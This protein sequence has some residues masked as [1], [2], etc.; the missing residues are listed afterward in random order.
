MFA[1]LFLGLLFFLY[2]EID[3]NFSYWIRSYR[4]SLID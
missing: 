1:Y 3:F 4:L 2:I